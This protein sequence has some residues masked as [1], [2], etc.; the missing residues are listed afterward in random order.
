MSGYRVNCS[1]AFS[2]LESAK[3]FPAFTE[4]VEDRGTQP[5]LRRYHFFDDAMVLLSAQPL[6]RYHE[7][8]NGAA[9]RAAPAPAQVPG[10]RGDHRSQR[11]L[12]GRPPSLG[13]GG[14]GSLSLSL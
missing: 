4:A 1:A 9:S 3:C 11:Y 8:A 2:Y 12:A 7:L 13:H 10:F 14:A 5:Q 6:A